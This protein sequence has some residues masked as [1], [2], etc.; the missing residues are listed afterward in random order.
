MFDFYCI[1]FNYLVLDY[2]FIEL[3]IFICLLLGIFWYESICRFVIEYFK[4]WDSIGCNMFDVSNI[5]GLF[6]SFCCWL[7]CCNDFCN[8]LVSFGLILVL[9]L[10]FV[11]R[12]WC[13]ICFN[14][15]VKVMIG[16]FFVFCVIF[17]IIKCLSVICIVDINMFGFWFLGLYLLRVC[18]M[19]CILWMGMFLNNKV[20]RILIIVFN[21]NIFGI[22]F[23][24]NLGCCLV[25][26]FSSCCVFLCFNNW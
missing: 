2:W 10:L 9:F 18:I 23:L 6:L 19:V 13:N 7:V 14:F 1:F 16:I 15:G 26:I 5:V 25:S 8:L 4:K 20:W 3:I 24:I 22:S 11:C 12:D 17:W 21:G